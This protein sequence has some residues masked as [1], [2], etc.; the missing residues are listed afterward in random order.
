MTLPES[1]RENLQFLLAETASHLAL[2]KEY[3]KLPSDSIPKRLLERQGYVE[4]LRLTIHDR[5]LKRMAAGS[6]HDSERQL[7]RSVESVATHLERIC[8]LCRDALLQGTHLRD[9]G[10]LKINDYLH[11]LDQVDDGLEL[12]APALLQKDTRLALKIGK[13]ERR[14]DRAYRIQLEHCVATLKE[15]GHQADRI[16]LVLLAHRIEQMGDAL[17]SISEAIISA[18]MGQHINTDRYHAIAASIGGLKAVNDSGRV[19]LETIAETRSGSS[20]NAVSA[21]GSDSGYHAILKDGGKRKLKEERQRVNDWHEIIPGL[22][23]KILSYQK[24]GDSAALLIEHLAGETF[25]QILLHGS[26][27]LLQAALDQLTRTLD[28]VWLETRNKK[29]VCAGYMK[30]LAKR[31]DD[32]YAIHPKF[33]QPASRIGSLKLPSFDQLLERMHAYEARVTAPF[34]V[35]IHGDFNLDNIIYDAGEGR[36]NFIDLH[37]SRYMDYVQDVSVFMVS[38]YRLQVFDPRVRRRI[39]ALCLAF[40]R[41]VRRFARNTGDQDFEVR[42]ALGLIRSFA[43]ST[44]FILDETLSW[45]MFNRASY[46]MQRLLE[47]EEEGKRFKTPVREIFVD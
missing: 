16:T 37:R 18:A 47:A 17:L 21:T 38:N 30:Q 33:R 22:A 10:L 36:I 9:H 1:I 29:P 8:E 24:H 25:E 4:N 40:Y 45:S 42:L 27:A 11:M 39:A 6:E 28:R 20:V 41:F 34:S 13:M 43:T 19:Q 46:L 35:Y 23:P 5:C 2:L 7:Y 12:I 44:R 31:M 26:D 14:L 3:L 15:Q 32:V